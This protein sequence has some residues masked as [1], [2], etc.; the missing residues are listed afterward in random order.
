VPGSQRDTAR[1]RQP[2]LPGGAANV[3]ACPVTGLP[4]TDR[5]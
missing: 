1:R 5:A 4:G 3:R 2:P